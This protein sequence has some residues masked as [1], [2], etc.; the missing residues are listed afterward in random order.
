MRQYLKALRTIMKD[1]YFTG[2]RTGVGTQALPGYAYR[3]KMRMSKDGVIHGFPLLTTKKINLR[4]VF[5]ELKWKLSGSTN[6]R[7]LLEQDVHIWT[8]WPFKK[9]LKATGEIDK[10]EWYVDDE[11]SD[12]SDE[13]KQRKKVFEEI[14]LIDEEFAKEWGELGPT[15]GHHMRDFGAIKLLMSMAGIEGEFDILV[16]GTDQLANVIDMIKN[17]PESRRNI[18]SLWNPPD[19]SKTLLPPCPCFYQLFA[20]QEGYLHMNVYQR[21]CDSFL[22]VPFNDAQEALLLAMLAIITGRKPGIL[23][24]FFGDFHIYN[25]HRNQVELQ[26]TRKPRPLPSLKINYRANIHDFVWSDFL[27]IG[28][29]P[30]PAIRAP[31]SV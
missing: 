23:N 5:E 6:I 29:D 15:Y 28:Y 2:D 14:I 7:P 17:D 18:M 25:N 30:H 12:F 20:N 26:L 19:N 31:V 9:W 27:L 16:P 4:L 13:W 1:G 24:H 21:S 11:K 22:G 8:E 3:M 10:F